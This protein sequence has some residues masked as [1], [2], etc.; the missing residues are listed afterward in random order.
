VG[1]QPL[2]E[3]KETEAAP[4]FLLARNR[5]RTMGDLRREKKKKKERKEKACSFFSSLRQREK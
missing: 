5:S 2:C 3:P 4:L 1:D